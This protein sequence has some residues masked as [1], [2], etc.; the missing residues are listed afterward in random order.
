MGRWGA[1]T[2]AREV[3]AILFDG[4]STS[5][6]RTLTGMRELPPPVGRGDRAL[7]LLRPDGTVARARLL[8]A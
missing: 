2:A 7:W 5:E 8:T 3:H 1:L 6:F 4:C